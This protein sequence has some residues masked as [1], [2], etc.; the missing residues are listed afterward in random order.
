MRLW[1]L[2]RPHDQKVSLN[3]TLNLN[4]NGCVGNLNLNLNLKGVGPTLL[5]LSLNC[6]NCLNWCL[7]LD[8]NLKGV[9]SCPTLHLTF[10]LLKL[11]RTKGLGLD[12]MM[13]R[14]GIDRVGGIEVSEGRDGVASI[15]RVA[16]IGLS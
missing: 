5:Q 6:L 2:A 7:T 15:G 9:G 13:C 14:M 12:M 11:A 3:L 1:Y 4:L 16:Q 8:L 10:C